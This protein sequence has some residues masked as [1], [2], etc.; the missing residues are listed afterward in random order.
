MHRQ[1]CKDNVLFNAHL[2]LSSAGSW[3]QDQTTH[4]C[5]G[6]ITYAQANRWIVDISQAE[7]IF[8]PMFNCKLCW[9]KNIKSEKFNHVPTGTF[10]YVCLQTSQAN[11][12][13]F[14]WIY[15]RNKH[16]KWFLDFYKA[17]FLVC[18]GDF[19]CSNVLPL[20]LH[21]TVLLDT[22]DHCEDFIDVRLA[23]H[24]QGE[25][26]PPCIMHTPSLD[27]RPSSPPDLPPSGRGLFP[28]VIDPVA[29]RAWDRGWHTP[30]GNR[31]KVTEVMPI[32]RLLILSW[33][34][35]RPT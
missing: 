4:H 32:P 3:M 29:M 15:L 28:T 21:Q 13:S 14:K 23:Q 11:S 10:H 19:S 9:K 30:V 12:F 24:T 22:V 8:S 5:Q 27:P 6:T 7:D 31:G 25:I 35:Q 34:R 16:S 17:I 2:N 18:R 33:C 1:T 26:I 20:R